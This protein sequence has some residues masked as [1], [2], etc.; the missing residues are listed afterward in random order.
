MSSIGKM[1]GAFFVGR[2][3]IVDWINSTL[4]LNIAKV[5]QT[6]SGAIACQLLDI[7]YPNQVGIHKVNWGAKQSFEFV[8][9]YKVLQTAFQKLKIEK[10]V[11]VDK[12]I[13]GKYQDNLEF[14][15]W[16]KRF[17]E[18]HISDSSSYD[19][20]AQRLRGKG[21]ST[22]N[23]SF[24]RLA[25]SAHPTARVTNPSQTKMQR[26]AS[27]VAASAKP[28]SAKPAAKPTSA[29][30][31]QLKENTAPR[32]PVSRET[33][34][35]APLPIKAVGASV[36]K[37]IAEIVALKA[38]AEAN[39]GQMSEMK[40]EIDGLEKERDF[41]FDKLRDIEMMLQVLIFFRSCTTL[42]VASFF[43]N[44]HPTLRRRT[45]HFFSLKSAPN[46]SSSLAVLEIIYQTN[47]P[48]PTN[49]PIYPQPP[50]TW[51]TPARETN[52]RVAFSKFSTPPP[53]ASVLPRAKTRV[54]CFLSLR[55][56]SN[57]RRCPWLSDKTSLFDGD[58]RQILDQRRMQMRCWKRSRG[59][60]AI[61]SLLF[62]CLVK[63]T[64]DGDYYY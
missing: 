35:A 25:G 6:A 28:T 40:S 20:T 4:D 43:A 58:T 62:P 34:R 49:N 2:K 12:L 10:Y 16:F 13:K 7:M 21:G 19:A 15:Q 52:L 22:Y 14:M 24:G 31:A 1:D 38:T 42:V 57:Q 26:G 18:M 64:V 3:E 51:K 59:A 46:I 30:P 9:N 53:K 39:A 47:T 48:E 56:I 33:T 17:F 5:E 41:Y 50:R 37:Y 61:H 36:E 32:A 55:R 11:D 8:N 29:K 63:E 44:V 45:V 27:K 60:S 54:M 23:A